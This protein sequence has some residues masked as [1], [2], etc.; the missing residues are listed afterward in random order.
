MMMRNLYQRCVT[1]CAWRRFCWTRNQRHISLSVCPS[2]PSTIGNWRKNILPLVLWEVGFQTRRH[3]KASPRPN[4]PTN[5]VIV[6]KERG[7]DA[8]AMQIFWKKSLRLLQG[9]S[10][11]LAN[12]DICRGSISFGGASLCPCHQETHFAG[13][14][15][16]GIIFC[17]ASCGRTIYPVRYIF[18]GSLLI[19]VCYC[20]INECFQRGLWE[21]RIISPNR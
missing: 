16:W 11:L 3:T 2:V 15:P 9:V 10:Q 8:T 21:G 17:I 1:F 20:F 14:I 7:P 4:S 5:C 6:E 13:S 12:G 18:L 19:Y